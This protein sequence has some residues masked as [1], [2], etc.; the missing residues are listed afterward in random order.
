MISGKIHDLI[1][2]AL[3]SVGIGDRDFVVE[4]PLDL[5]N[6]DY[7]TNVAM[8]YPKE[9]ESILE[10]IKKNL[11]KEIEKVE[12]VGPGFINFYL[13]RDFFIESLE[14]V[15]EKG[16]D[17][18]KN[19]S[20]KGEKTIVE[21]TDPNPFKEF[22]IGHLMS[23]AIGEAVSRIV[24]WSGSEVK[25]FCFQGDVG[26]HVAKAIWGM[27][28][29]EKDPYPAGAKAYEESEE[30]KGEIQ[31]INK[32]IYDRSDEEVN[33]LYDKGREE[34]LS[35]FEKIYKKLDTKFDHFV[36]ESE[37]GGVGEKI[38]R[39]NIGKVFEESEGAVVF[40]GSH[41]R[42]VINSQ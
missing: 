17:F 13:S 18:G 24:E 38:V 40:K 30:V 9:K 1:D 27:L 4:Y 25:R 14:K 35:E 33:K 5:K 3:E 15:V 2:K 31:E 12:M 42:V 21:Y 37:T 11:P 6:G 7:S 41:T 29:G 36:F 19:E 20:A 28:K 34:S 23:N 22:H 16:G 32:K 39:D 26:I 10:A 8:K